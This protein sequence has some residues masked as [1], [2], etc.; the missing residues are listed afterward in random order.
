MSS[1]LLAR[2][3]EL[4]KTTLIPHTRIARVVGCST[5]TLYTIREGTNVPNV[6]LCEAIYNLLSR[7]ELEVK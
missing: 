1:K 3:S 5:R 6:E 7:Y 4:L 2:T